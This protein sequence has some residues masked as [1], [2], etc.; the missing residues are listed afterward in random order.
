MKNVIAL[1][2]F[3][4]AIGLFSVYVSPTYDEIKTLRAEKAQ[5]DE[6]LTDS[7]KI[8]DVR[9]DL[10]AK[11]NSFAPNDIKR[12][13]KLLPNHVDSIRLIIE[14]DGLASRYNMTLK[15]VQ[16]T[17]P[18]VSSSLYDPSQVVPAQSPSYGTA[19][20]SFE[21][22]GTYETYRNF[23]KDLEYSLRVV[24][25][26]GVA[27]TAEKDEKAGLNKYNFKTSMQTYW[28]TE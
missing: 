9:D 22:S 17:I 21:V 11:Y 16:V 28:L 4:A 5:Y 13:E 27:F 18:T 10:L 23:I 8:Q 12:L 3:V 15:N 19:Q 26:T 20:G 6:A 24:D 7:Q 25:V 14:I 1:L 2:L